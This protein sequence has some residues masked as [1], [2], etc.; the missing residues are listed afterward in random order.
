MSPNHLAGLVLGAP[1]AY[2][3]S[4]VAESIAKVLISR[5]ALR[6]SD[7]STRAAI[8]RGIGEAFARR[9]H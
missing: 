8:L 1:V 5:E 3:V 2:A 6:D 9:R 4:V 7:A